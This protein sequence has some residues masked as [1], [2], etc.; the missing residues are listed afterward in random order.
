[1]KFGVIK[2]E[3]IANLVNIPKEEG[4]KLLERFKL[5]LHSQKNRILKE[6]FSRRILTKEDYE[7]Y[8]KDMF[9][10]EF[11]FD[12]FLQYLDGVMN[13]NADYF[14]TLNKN[15]IKRRDELERKFKLKVIT[16]EELEKI[17]QNKN[18]NF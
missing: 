1:M 4:E 18:N 3:W 17:S 5:K 7:S 16:P 6:A 2:K 13:A 12:G 15:L 11:G 9:Y 14:V 10:D 8:Y